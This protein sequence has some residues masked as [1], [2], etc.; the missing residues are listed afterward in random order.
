MFFGGV[1]KL[2]YDVLNDL[3]GCFQY[4]KKGPKVIFVRIKV[5]DKF[6]VPM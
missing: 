6:Y 5:S 1:S 4:P 2:K 3:D